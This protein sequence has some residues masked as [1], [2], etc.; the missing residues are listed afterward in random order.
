M[1]LE[2]TLAAV[3]LAAGCLLWNVHM[4]GGGGE[5]ETAGKHKNLVT[6]QERLPTQGQG[7]AASI[8]HIPL[9]SDNSAVVQT[10][11]QQAAVA[12]ST[13]FGSGLPAGS[14]DRQGQFPSLKSSELIKNAADNL[15]NSASIEANARITIRLFDEY[16][17]AKGKYYQMGLG[18]TNARLE[19]EFGQSDDATQVVQICDGRFYYTLTES[20]KEKRLEFVNLE[21]V[22]MVNG[23][24]QSFVG[25]PTNLM[26]TGGI[27]SVLQNL[28]AV[29]DFDAP[30]PSEL[31]GI[32]MLTL[33]GTWKADKLNQF[34]SELVHPGELDSK[35][36]WEELPRQIPHAVSVTLGNDSN[37]PLF[38]YRIVFYQYDPQTGSFTHPMLTLELFEV[39]RSAPLSQNLFALDSSKAITIDATERYAVR[40]LRYHEIQA[41][42]QAA[43]RTEKKA[44]T[45]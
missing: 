37:F 2:L 3:L 10:G 44:K 35:N 23:S 1:K 19:F 15:L 14:I 20:K 25:D 16:V 36:G 6:A 8:H 42:Q 28:A 9:A 21:R 26:A 43:K 24:T 27:A 40:V 45:R 13:P 34:V 33:N 41:E 11:F 39:G 7:S 32:S 38:P 5:G 4:I 29:F 18:S 30:V 12:H 22:S 31:G 17:V